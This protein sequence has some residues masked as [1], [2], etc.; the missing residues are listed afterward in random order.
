MHPVKEGS[1]YLESGSTLVQPLA[2]TITNSV[3]GGKFDNHNE[4]AGTKGVVAYAIPGSSKML[5][6]YFYNPF[7]DDLSD[8]TVKLAIQPVGPA[9]AGLL[10]KVADLKGD[11][12]TKV[13]DSFY[14][15]NQGYKLTVCSAHVL[16]S[17]H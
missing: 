9:N 14:V 5:V 3:I 12:L 1:V 2:A 11:G 7:S 15:D 8:F 16:P 4:D 10:K 13:E 17:S 6:V